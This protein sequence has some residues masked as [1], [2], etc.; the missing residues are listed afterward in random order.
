ME[1]RGVWLAGVEIFLGMAFLILVC[2]LWACAWVAP[3]G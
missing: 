2:G 3:W 1:R